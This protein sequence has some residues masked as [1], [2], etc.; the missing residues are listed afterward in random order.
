MA[1]SLDMLVGDFDR[2]TAVDELRQHYDS[3]PRSRRRELPPAGSRDGS[4]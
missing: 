4:I 3:G 2:A 1:E